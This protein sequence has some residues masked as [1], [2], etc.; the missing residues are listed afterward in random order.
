MAAQE[1]LPKPQAKNNTTKPKKDTGKWCEFHK[2]STHNTSECR[3]KQ[4]LADDVKA[5][6][7]DTFYEFESKPD[8]GNDKRKQIIDAN[9]NAIVATA[10]IQKE[11]LEDPKEEEHLFQS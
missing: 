1:I 6:E 4:S 9:P 8:K 7:S 10:K 3:L 5:F 2:N 11:K